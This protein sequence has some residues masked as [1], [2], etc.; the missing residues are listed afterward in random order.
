MV[1]LI[2]VPLVTL[3][4]DYSWAEGK[5]GLERFEETGFFLM[6]TLSEGYTEEVALPNTS[7]IE[8][9]TPS[10]DFKEGIQEIYSVFHFRPNMTGFELWVRVAVEKAEGLSSGKEI[11]WDGVMITAGENSALLKLP[12]PPHGW[13][14]GEYL[15]EFFVN[16]PVRN[17]LERVIRFTVSPLK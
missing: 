8:P 1:F 6:I 15:A 7:I 9:V 5:K 14:A 2:I 17:N 16:A 13:S 11:G 10:D 12:A 3:S 4:A